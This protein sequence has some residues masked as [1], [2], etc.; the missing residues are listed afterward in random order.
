MRAASD[1]PA[2]VRTARVIAYVQGGLLALNALF[3]TFG[4]G[5]VAAA[6]GW[7]GT[8]GIAAAAAIGVALLLI[9]GLVIWAGVLVGKLS[10]RARI[11]LLIYEG[12][13]F[14]LGLLSLSQAGVGTGILN[15]LIAV[16]VI[17][18]LQFDAAT[19]AAFLP[20]TTNAR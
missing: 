7:A 10:N 1:L 16:V 11:G 19:K 17:Y 2:G 13:S 9:A 8:G 3:F 12:L 20:A 5:A 15:L 14:A 6:Y 18:Y 4:A